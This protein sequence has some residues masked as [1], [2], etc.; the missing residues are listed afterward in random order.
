M[1]SDDSARLSRL[2][3]KVSSLESGA[4]NLRREFAD[5]KRSADRAGQRID[6]LEQTLK[7]TL[8]E[9]RTTLDEFYRQY[10][11]DRV[12]HDAHNRL[13][14][15]QRDWR[16]E[17]GRFADARALAA[18]IIDII[19][20]NSISRPEIRSA[21]TQLAIR[22]PRYWLARATLAVAAWLDEDE[23][24]YHDAMNGALALDPGK[25]ALFMTLLLRGHKRDGIMD[26]W[27]DTYFSGLEPTNLPRHFQVVIDAVTGGAFGK[28][29]AARLAWRMTEWYE[30]AAQS[31]DA[32]ADAISEWKRRLRSLAV[33][34]DYAAEFP[35]LARSCP[36]W[37]ALRERHVINTAIVAAEAHFRDRFEAGAEVTADLGTA[38][39]SLLRQLAE[40]PDAAEEK[41]LR[42]IR[43]AEAVIETRDPAAAARQVAAEEA[44]LTGSL[45]IVSMVSTAAF[46][47]PSDGSLPRPTPTELLAIVL[48]KRLVS[49]AAQQLHD[50]L[51]ALPGVPL[52]HGDGLWEWQQDFSWASEAEATPT[53]LRRQA[54]E[55]MVALTA[56][57]TARATDQRRKLLRSAVLACGGALLVAICL[58]GTSFAGT[59][60]PSLYLRVPGIALL[61]VAL[62]VGWRIVPQVSWTAAAKPRELDA[63]ANTLQ[64]AAEELGRF[65]AQER[66]SRELLPK[67]RQYLHGLNADHAY[68][69][70]RFTSSPTPSASRG[71]PAWTPTP[72]RK[73]PEIQQSDGPPPLPRQRPVDPTLPMPRPAVDGPDDP[74]DTAPL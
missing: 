33:A 19:G 17:F 74:D 52:H 46:P 11:S 58:L 28:E 8:A 65:L 69:A 32:E 44:D 35:V 25:T 68:E 2:A 42:R 9:V 36:G 38:I 49:A 30:D 3:S 53:A 14:A 47:K 12:V 20:T 31:R 51:P 48:S 26:E 63:M 40:T 67:L 61:A 72:P 37:P 24:R 45:N 66:R 41:Y 21:T 64:A 7:S 22:T 16:R 71:L 1:D 50:E 56:R 29:S 43:E 5:V 62:A 10:K 60:V 27:V 4:A 73:Q 23:A 55:H 70:T 59:A 15:A 34:R 54:G 18:N 57:L 6:Q 13:T 39:G